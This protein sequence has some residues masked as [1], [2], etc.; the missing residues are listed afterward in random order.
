VAKSELISA[1]SSLLT[2]YNALKKAILDGITDSLITNAEI[3]LIN[4]KTTLYK[5]ASANYKEKF[6]KAIDIIGTKKVK[7][8]EVSTTKKMSLIEQKA[9]KITLTVEA[10]YDNKTITNNKINK[11]INDYKIV[12][13]TEFDDIIDSHLN[14]ET[15]MNGAFKDGII[16]EAE[17][18]SINE[19]L[20]SLEKEKA[21]IDKEYSVIIA[22]SSLTGTA[23]SE[24]ISASTGIST[25]YN[26]LKKAILDGITDSLITNIEI[27]LIN[28]KTELYK[29]A[30][31]NYK[32]KFTKALDAIQ[33]L[34]IKK[35]NSTITENDKNTKYEISK[36]EQKANKIDLEV[37]EKV[38][39]D[40]IVAKINMTSEKIKIAAKFL[41]LHGLV[42]FKN[43]TDGRTIISGSN[44]KTGEIEAIDITG[45]NFRG[46]KLFYMAPNGT[47][48]CDGNT[49]IRHLYVPE[50]H[51][52]WDGIG[53]F[54]VAP[55]GYF[56]NEIRAGGEIYSNN[57]GL[58]KRSNDAYIKVD[59]IAIQKSENGQYLE[60]AGYQSN[61][62]FG[63]DI[64]YS[65]ANLKENINRINRN[66]KPA[67]N[68]KI[69]LDLINSINHFNFNYKENSDFVDCGYIAQDL[70]KNNSDLV[71]EVKQ[72]D[73]SIVLEP[74]ASLIIPN[75]SLAIK[76]QQEQINL[77]KEQIKSLEIT[78][79]KKISIKI[80]EF[81]SRYYLKSMQFFKRKVIK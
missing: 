35:V 14:L 22:N 1:S 73:G 78:L 50:T 63:V 7:D 79:N 10:N 37:K 48:A 54:R 20:V 75:L 16:S 31:A 49:Y 36:I 9:D 70:Q 32:E 66:S 3:N 60:I 8:L 44:I 28:S 39:N 62:V 17:A 34:E 12:V 18:N 74:V 19:R 25:S 29:T 56:D 23:K 5:T 80:N 71:R 42:E 69:G 21:D 13:D 33:K 68:K 27:N 57:Q 46:T 67:S 53:S 59:K 55:T 76:E 51:P 52:S 30:S 65:D 81:C 40:E 15:E 58:I 6:T 24:L 47:M 43:L 77:L 2:S 38:G 72:N 64:W 26:A 4:A 11:A 45:C 41:E 61:H